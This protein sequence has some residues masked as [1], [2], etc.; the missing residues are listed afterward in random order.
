MSGRKRLCAALV[1]LAAALPAAG[2]SLRGIRKEFADVGENVIPA[3]VIVKSDQMKGPGGGSTGVIIHP[4]GYVLS[5]ADAT[6]ITAERTPEGEVKKTHGMDAIVQLPYPD[7]RKFKAVVIRRDPETDSTLLKIT[8]ER[9]E[10]L[11]FVP[12]GSS[13]GLLVGAFSIIVGNM[14]GSGQEGEPALSMGCVSALVNRTGLGGGKYEMIYTSAAVNPGMNGGPS[15]DAEGR[16]V[17]IISTWEADPASPF[18]ALGKVTPIDRIRARYADLDCFDEVFPDP[19]TLKP[20]SD[21]AAVLEQAFSIVA[22]HTYPSVVSIEVDRGGATKPIKMRMQNPRNPGGPPLEIEMPRYRGPYSG[23]VLSKDGL[24]LTC[25]ANL[26]AYPEIKGITVHLRDGRSLPG[27]VRARDRYRDVALIEVEATDLVPL[28]IAKEPTVGRF[29]LAVGNPFGE[30]RHDAPL[31]TYG[32]VSG[33]HRLNRD[34]DAIQ[35]DAG[36]TDAMVG[37][38]LVTLEGELLGLNLLVQPERFGRNSG[39]GFAIPM[40][41]LETSL[42]KLRRGD[43]VLPGTLSVQ[44]GTNDEQAYVCVLVVPNGPAAKGGMES[45]DVILEV[46]SR[47]ASSFASMEELIDF[48]REKGPGYNL[49]VTVGRGENRTEHDLVITMGTKEED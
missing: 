20:R 11:H 19:R 6:I 36:L 4:S 34:L 37:G 27:K 26:W 23:V 45:G 7:L 9:L 40:T 49:K 25:N 12:M 46:E 42:P 10:D 3:T 8:E 32:I 28:P 30:D 1:V 35:T 44:F 2:Q 17:G 18:R 41:S 39:I 48:I 15:L 43:D 13:D 31:L 33:V 21:E 29:A 14:F 47:R 22:R 5:D 24:V 16:L 38:A